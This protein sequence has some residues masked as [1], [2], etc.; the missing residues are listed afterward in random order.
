VQAV[1]T[2]AVAVAFQSF[3]DIKS[4]HFSNALRDSSV[5]VY[6]LHTSISCSRIGWPQD[7]SP[8]CA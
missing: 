3:N 1:Y 8:M 5:Y 2:N 6:Q 4:K 7:L